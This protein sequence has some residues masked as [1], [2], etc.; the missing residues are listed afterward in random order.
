MG[1]E[2]GWGGGMNGSLQAA[3]LDVTPSPSHRFKAKLAA[4]ITSCKVLLQA[5]RYRRPCPN[6]MA[7]APRATPAQQCQHL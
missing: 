5:N 6:V 2:Q 4:K 3:T 1:A 7:T